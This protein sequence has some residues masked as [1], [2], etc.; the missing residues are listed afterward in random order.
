MTTSPATILNMSPFVVA[1]SEN[2]IP[3]KIQN[4]LFN[5]DCSL[6]ILIDDFNENCSGNQVHDKRKM[7]QVINAE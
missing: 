2:L 3:D 5:V 1:S 7:L 4:L 6:E